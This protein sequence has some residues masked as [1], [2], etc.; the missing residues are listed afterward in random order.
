MTSSARRVD[1]NL[2]IARARL[3]LASDPVVI[4]TET[5]GFGPLAEIC[6]FAAINREGSVLV[7]TLV[8][9]QRPIPADATGVHGIANADVA[10]SPSFHMVLA[11][12]L[13]ELLVR[14][15]MPIATYNAEYDL[16]LMD[17]S[18]GGGVTDVTGR[19]PTASWTSMRGTTANGAS[20]TVPTHGSP[21][22]RPQHSVG[23]D[24]MDSP[25]GRWPMHGWPWECLS[26][27]RGPKGRAERLPGRMSIVAQDVTLVRQSARIRHRPEPHEQVL[28]RIMMNP[29]GT[30][31]VAV[32]R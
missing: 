30:A 1:R 18:S 27:W 7:N 24:G 8:R 29:S 16:R 28:P 14:V 23:S 17:Q 22:A 25:T 15:D 4:D 32:S 26:T 19:T 10:D 11:E 9:P 20:V 6:E 2:A 13:P 3:L 31:D 5:T 12:Y 21:W